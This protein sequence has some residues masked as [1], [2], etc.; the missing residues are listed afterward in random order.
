[1]ELT[2]DYYNSDGAMFTTIYPRDHTTTW[3]NLL[4]KTPE[5]SELISE[6]RFRNPRAVVV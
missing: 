4:N 3:L 2:L 6:V 1:M 5:G